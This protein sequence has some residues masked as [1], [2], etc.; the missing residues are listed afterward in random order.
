MGADGPEIGMTDNCTELRDALGVVFPNM[1][2]MLSVMYVPHFTTGRY[3][4]F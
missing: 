2:L 3:G 4:D 1:K